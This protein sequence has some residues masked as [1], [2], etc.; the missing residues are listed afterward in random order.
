MSK[1]LNFKN[2]TNFQKN[3]IILVFQKFE[4][5]TGG[6]NDDDRTETKFNKITSFQM[7]TDSGILNCLIPI[8]EPLT[9]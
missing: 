3:F 1:Y 7:M 4:F 9:D 2:G 6:T 8:F 5:H